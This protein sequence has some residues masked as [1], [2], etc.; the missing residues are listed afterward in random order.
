M[1][2]DGRG[3]GW[4]E[5]GERGRGVSE[6]FR[7]DM[8]NAER[9]TELGFKSDLPLLTFANVNNTESGFKS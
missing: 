4:R 7:V 8:P 3:G 5:G 1:W 2:R 6:S 9:Q